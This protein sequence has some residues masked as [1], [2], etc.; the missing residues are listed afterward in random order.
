MARSAKPFR[1]RNPVTIGAIS[2]TVIAALVLLAFNAQSLPFIGGGTVYT[3]RFTEAAGLQPDD[4]VR[5]A[6]V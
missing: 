1:D 2:L 6:G 5:V 3:A 4:P